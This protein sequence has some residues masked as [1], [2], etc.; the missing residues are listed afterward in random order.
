MRLHK[1]NLRTILVTTIMVLAIA[2]NPIALAFEIL[3]TETCYGYRVDT[4]APKGEGSAFFTHNEKV[5]FWVKISDPP[6]D[7][8]IRVIWIDPDGDQYD[9][10]SVEVMMMEGEEWG[11]IFDS[12]N[13]A[14]SIPENKPGLWRV[15]LS[16]DHTIE[17][18]REFNLLN[19]D[20]FIETIKGI[21]DQVEVI[22]NEKNELQNQ[23]QVLTAKNTALEANY[24]KLLAQTGTS[25]E[26][27]QL[28]NDY[29]ALED[30]YRDLQVT[31]STTRMMMY[32]AV[33]VAIASVA[34]AVYFG[35]IKR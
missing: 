6:S 34:V 24:T 13:I 18:A 20:E 25:S 28:Q 14:N 9:S 31:L 21:Q 5:G 3:D 15:E 16:I 17:T 7:V 35:A 23:V 8:D 30:D 4:Y 2:S 19:Y 11:I 26:Y 22:V 1:R 27:E 33:V 32:G 10:N 12:I 29:D